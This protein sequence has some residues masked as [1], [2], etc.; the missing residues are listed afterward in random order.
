MKDIKKSN[1][2]AAE[3]YGNIIAVSEKNKDAKWAKT[4]VKVL[5]SDKIKKFITDKYDG[6][7]VPLN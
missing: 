1:S 3:T 5:K 2:E 4:L 6:G 7:V